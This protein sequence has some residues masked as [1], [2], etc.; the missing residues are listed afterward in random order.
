MRRRKNEAEAALPGQDLVEQGLADLAGK[1]T[2]DNSLLL[3]IAAPRLRRL[4]FEIPAAPSPVPPEHQLYDRL[5]ARLGTAAHSHYN[6]LI[7]RIV[8]FAHVLERESRRTKLAR[9]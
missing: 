1:R 5:A 6:A 3:L 7:R 2:T 4:G 8:S 9:Y